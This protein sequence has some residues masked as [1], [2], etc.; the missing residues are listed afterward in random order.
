MNH[1]KIM[2]GLSVLILFFAITLCCAKQPGPSLWNTPPPELIA[3]T[4]VF[5]SVVLHNDTFSAFPPQL[6]EYYK[7]GFHQ[8]IADT[9]E[10]EKRRSFWSKNVIF[11]RL[12]VF[13]LLRPYQR[14]HACHYHPSRHC[15]LHWRLDEIQNSILPVFGWSSVR[16][17]WALL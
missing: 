4:G 15:K 9:G 8:P 7:P 16:M 17:L 12:T 6:P 1:L 5:A 10:G 14:D 3:S 11:A 13:A 2:S